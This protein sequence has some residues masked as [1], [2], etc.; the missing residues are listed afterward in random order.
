MK[1]STVFTTILLSAVAAVQGAEIV[2]PIAGSVLPANQPFNLTYASHRFAKEHTIKI[3][4]VTS[5]PA[6]T[7]RDF[8]AGIGAQDVK[9]N[10]VGPDGG[11]VYSLQVDP[12][13]L[14]SAVTGDRNIYVVESFAAFGGS[15]DGLE[16]LSVPVTF[17]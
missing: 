4:V 6:G 3:T 1:F 17:V 16:I 13:G 7:G 12:V 5:A 2:S 11:A 9:P 14:F 10:G 15:N 8:P